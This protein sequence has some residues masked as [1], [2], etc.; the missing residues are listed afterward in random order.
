MKKQ[1]GPKPRG[2]TLVRVITGVLFAAFLLYGGMSLF[3]SLENP[4]RTTLAVSVAV[5]KTS[6]ARGYI[7]REE[8]VVRGSGFI[9]PEVDDGVR[10]AKDSVVAVSYGSGADSGTVSEMRELKTRIERL[11]AA[12]GVSAEER[13]SRSADAIS[14]LALSLSRRDLKAASGGVIEAESLIMGAVDAESAQ[15]EIIS[16][17]RELSALMA[18][19]PYSAPITAP[20]SG[21]FAASIDG[22]EN[23]SPDDIINLTADRAHLAP[24][25]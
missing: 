11:R 24:V 4:F 1:K 12:A 2:E 21:A 25:G 19:V 16:L 14:D 10:A 8:R 22:F 17:E 18:K 13:S 5:S 7:V 6:A 15:N 20:E 23:I 9:V 3:R